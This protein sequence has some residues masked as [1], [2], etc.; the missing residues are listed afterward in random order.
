[1]AAKV[2]AA[3][4]DPAV[5]GYLVVTKTDGTLKKLAV[6]SLVSRKGKVA[7]FDETTGGLIVVPEVPTMDAMN[8]ALAAAEA[9]QTAAE[10]SAAAA[11][12]SENKARHLASD[13]VDTEPEPGIP[14]ALASAIR[15]AE[16]ATQIAGI[17]I[18]EL[19]DSVGHSAYIY[20]PVVADLFASLDRTSNDCTSIRL[21]AQLHNKNSLDG[22]PTW[23]FMTIT[24]RGTNALNIVP[25]STTTQTP[26]NLLASWQGTPISKEGGVAVDKVVNV[27][28]PAGSNR[29]LWI[30][31]AEI[32][33]QV[34][35][36]TL[37]FD[38]SIGTKT[39]LVSDTA[40]TGRFSLTPAVNAKSWQVDL[41]DSTTPTG[42]VITFHLPANLASFAYRI[43]AVANCGGFTSAAGQSYT[44]TLTTRGKTL[45][46]P[47]KGGLA[48]VFF[49]Q[50]GTV[51]DA[52][53][54]TGLDLIG[55]PATTGGREFKDLSMIGGKAYRDASTS[56]TGT[57]TFE[58][59]K[60]GAYMSV[61]FQPV[62][63]GMDSVTILGPTSIAAG[64]SGDILVHSN[65]ILYYVRTYP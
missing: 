2:S 60:Q 62:S 5:E 14:S 37:D 46:C 18:R 34:A 63:G 61:A 22:R 33:L 6:P 1:M 11:L 58:D 28:I 42:V 57:A 43:E 56:I 35:S 24:N 52:T 13:P 38:I 9:A 50:G 59:N 16:Y 3:D 10:D 32:N 53:S 20:D 21:P 17:P 55:A 7:G 48:M 26:V 25:Q 19:G 64:K 65:G 49:G 15:A 41:S 47:S 54:L 12:A 39:V 45:T 23:S 27:T 29:K 44:D 4:A 8:A 51:N 36:H 31:A 30:A 40:P